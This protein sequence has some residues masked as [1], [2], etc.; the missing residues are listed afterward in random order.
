[1]GNI[2]AVRSA[3]VIAGAVFLEE[4]VNKGVDWVHI[5]I[6]ATAWYDSEKPYSA[7]G[8]SGWGISTALA[9]IKKLSEA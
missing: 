5:D 8:P 2:P 9:L 1:M 7:K 3:D 4:F 6:G